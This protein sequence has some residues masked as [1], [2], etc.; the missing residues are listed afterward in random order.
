MRNAKLIVPALVVL[1]AALLIGVFTA[2]SMGGNHDKRVVKTAK[3]GGRTILVNRSGM[4]LYHLSVERKGHFICTDKTCLS[5]WKPLVVKRGTTPTGAKSLG[6]VKRPDGRLQ[7]AYKGGPLYTFAEDKK[8]GDMKGNGFKDV[9]TW[10]VIAVAGKSQSTPT[11]S[12]GYGG[13]SG[14]Y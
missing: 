10:R 11:S 8:P 14:G 5:L 1:G 12:G 2:V 13:Y 3:V 9:G 4:T 7:V 6:T